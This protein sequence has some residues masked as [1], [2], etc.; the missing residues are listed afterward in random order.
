VAKLETARSVH[1]GFNY[2]PDFVWSVEAELAGGHR[3]R[4][5]RTIR[6]DDLGADGTLV[7]ASNLWFSRDLHFPSGSRTDLYPEDYRR[8]V[9]TRGE[10]EALRAAGISL[11]M[12]ALDQ[13]ALR[14]GL[15]ALDPP[16]HR[17]CAAYPDAKVEFATK[18]NFSRE[19]QVRVSLP[20]GPEVTPERPGYR[21]AASG[22]CLFAT[23]GR[24]AEAIGDGPVST[25]ELL[26]TTI[27]ERRTSGDGS[28]VPVFGTEGADLTAAQ[29][30]EL[31]A[32]RGNL[33]LL[34]R[35]L[36]ESR[37]KRRGGQPTD[38]ASGNR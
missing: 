15:A 3:L 20:L 30:D 24:S 6:R 5:S 38:G 7:Q 13:K 18:Q 9:A 2:R 19:G 25:V 31:I 36:A 8:I 12:A 35:W 16:L 11:G 22:S 1:G 33:E 17:L 14:Q 27:I 34:D 21:I 10:A 28:E 4:I 29:I 37:L 26:R 23:D 32:A